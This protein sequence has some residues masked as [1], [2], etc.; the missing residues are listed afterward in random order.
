MGVG[1]AVVREKAK[2]LV[3]SSWQSQA[4]LS[5]FL[6][7]EVVLAFVLPVLGFGRTHFRLYSEIGFS[8]LLISGVAIAWGQRWLFATSAAVAVAAIVVRAVAL[9]RQSLSWEIWS[10]G[11]GMAAILA[12]IIVLLEQVFRSGAVTHLRIQGAIAV[13]LLFGVEW[14]HAYH[15]VSLLL[16]GSFAV[17]GGQLATAGDWIYYS[18]VTLTTLGYGDITPVRPVA[19]TLAVGEALTGQ[20]YLAVLIARLIAMEIVSW[21][22]RNE[23]R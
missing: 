6:V 13:Y 4:N 19:R 2:H 20:L 14:S 16:P 15:I 9:F 21:Q 10:D 1:H 7:L 23:R 11:L 3:V 18:Y 22:Q 12:L 8:V 17:Q 5:F